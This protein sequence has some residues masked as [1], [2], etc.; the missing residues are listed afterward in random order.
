VSE[1]SEGKCEEELLDGFES[2]GREK[3]KEGRE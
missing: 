1:L 3:E 2:E